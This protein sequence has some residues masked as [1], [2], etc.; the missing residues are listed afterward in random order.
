M[1]PWEEAYRRFET[2]EQELRKFL[3]RLRW[4]GAPGWDRKATVLEPFC[5]RGSGVRA[6]RTLGF[7][8]VYGLDL[9]FTQLG[10]APGGAWIQADARALPLADRSVDIVSV[11]GGLHHLPGLA[12]VRVALAEMARVLQPEGRFLLVEPWLTPFLHLVHFCCNRR[13]LR[14]VSGRLDA[15]WTMT[16]YERIDYERWLCHPREV[17]GMLEERFS[18]VRSRVGWGKLMVVGTPRHGTGSPRTAPARG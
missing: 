5:G 11:H 4:A 10:A 14:R 17:H 12:D 16:A 8:R 6:W 3:R 1:T 13:F 9:S 7:T 15:F 18:L 2:P